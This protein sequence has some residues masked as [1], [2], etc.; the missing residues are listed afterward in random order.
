MKK[1]SFLFALSFILILASC[2]SNSYTIKGDFSENNFNGETIYLQT[3]DTVS[4]SSYIVIDS[5]VIKDNKFEFKGKLS[6][7]PMAGF[8]SI[9]D[10]NNP[11]TMSNLESPIATIVLEPG[12]IRVKFDK[13]AVAVGGTDKNAAMN[14]INELVN[15]MAALNNSALVDDSIMAKKE[16]II[17]AVQ[18][19]TFAFTK[20]NIKNKMGEYM[21]ISSIQYFTPQQNLELLAQTEGGF[22]KKPEVERLVTM[23]K[24][25]IAQDEAST[26]MENE[27]LN[28]PFIDAKLMNRQGEQ[29]SLSSFVGKGKYVLIDFWASWCGPCI[30][31]IPTLTEAY[32]MYKSKG[33]DI[34]G[35]SIDEDLSAWHKTI[36]SKG[37]A[38]THLSDADNSVAQL[39]K[40]PGIPCTLLTDKDGTIIAMNL[41]GQELLE[42]LNE[43]IK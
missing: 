23:F 29:V 35:I 39:Y 11:A 28:K 20:E 37:M 8:I 7:N 31:E 38:W 43:L 42:K 22:Q 25:I 30:Q 12:D 3:I 18:D 40:V 32:Q 27:L 33:F 21:L 34:V 13:A 17:K 4:W 41:R 14:K 1:L 24:Q 36:E 26:Q 9:G 5:T 15:Q 6:V 19:E 16:S 10:L 2:T